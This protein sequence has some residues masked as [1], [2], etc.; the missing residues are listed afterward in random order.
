LCKKKKKPPFGQRGF[1]TAEQ[2]KIVVATSISGC[3]YVVKGIVVAEK[4][5]DLLL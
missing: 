5:S 2:P 1:F 3:A 4:L